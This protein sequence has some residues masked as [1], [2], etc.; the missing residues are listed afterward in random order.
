MSRE[1]RGERREERGER[2]ETMCFTMSQDEDL[3]C[4]PMIK[5]PGDYQR[6]F[7]RFNSKM[8]IEGKLVQIVG[9]AHPAILF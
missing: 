2:R 5:D 4:K 1:E 7:V 6:N 8:M 3:P 9:F